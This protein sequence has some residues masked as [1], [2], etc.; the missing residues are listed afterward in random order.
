[1]TK[2]AINVTKVATIASKVATNATNGGISPTDVEANVPNKNPNA[3]MRNLETTIVKP[4]PRNTHLD[5]KRMFFPVP[6]SEPSVKD[7]NY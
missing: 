1:V 5:A 2:V 6:A 7:F 4:N 3:T